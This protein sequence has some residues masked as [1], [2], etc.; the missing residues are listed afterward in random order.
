MDLRYT[1]PTQIYALRPCH[2]DDARDLVAIGG[3]HSVQVLLLTPTEVKAIATFHIGTRITAIAWSSST[4]SPSSSDSWSL[5]LAVATDDHALHLLTKSANQPE[6]IFAFG[7]GLSGHHGIINDMTFCGGWTEDSSRYVATV[8]DDKMLM[9][10]DLH[11]ARDEPAEDSDLDTP[12]PRAQPTAYVIPFPHPLSSISSHP[13]TSKEFLV[14]DCRGSVYLTDWRSD[15]EDLL[16]SNLRN[17]TLI[18]LV[19]PSALAASCTGQSH[20]WTGFTAWR[21]DSLDVIGGVFGNK[22]AI[23]DLANLRG[24]KPVVTSQP[25]IEG[26]HRFRWCRTYPEHFAISIQIPAKG[27]IIQ[28]H[29]INFPQAQPTVFTLCSKPQFVRDFDFLSLR[30][31]PRIAAA[32]GRTVFIF[33]IGEES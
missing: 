21:S 4:V 1:H 14:S 15:S 5:Q 30:G 26:G 32:V 6:Y 31:I 23:W 16:Q 3:Q 24:G 7:G 22:F 20:R 11:P 18:E 13:L 9:V 25:V 12:P 2:N 10:W 17:S 19:D 33:A 29:N 8:S 28:V 27:A